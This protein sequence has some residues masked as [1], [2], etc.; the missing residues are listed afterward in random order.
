MLRLLGDCSTDGEGMADCGAGV[1]A[2]ESDGDSSELMSMMAVE[3][4]DFLK[5]KLKNWYRRRLDTL[6]CDYWM[7]ARD[8]Q[9][10]SSVVYNGRLWLQ[11]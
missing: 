2:G 9:Y 4:M 3:M 11:M 1:P 7:R 5:K 6:P 8:V 10:L